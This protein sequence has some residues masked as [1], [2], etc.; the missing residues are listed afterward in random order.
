MSKI[1]TVPT[2]LYVLFNNIRMYAQ[3]AAPR[4]DSYVPTGPKPVF[5]RSNDVRNIDEKP[6]AGEELYLSVANTVQKDNIVGIQQIRNLWRIY[7]NSH[8]DRV[9]VITDG[10][11]IRGTVAPVHDVNPFTRAKEENVTKLTIKDIPLSLSDEVIRAELEAQK[12][13]VKGKIVRQKLRVNGQLINCLNGDRVVYIR[14]PSQPLPRKVVFASSFM[15]RI[16]HLGQPQTVLT[17]SRCLQTGHHVSTCNADVRCRRCKESGHLQSS[18]PTTMRDLRNPDVATAANEIHADRHD[19]TPLDDKQTNSRSSK[20]DGIEG[21][22]S[23]RQTTLADFIVH[24]PQDVANENVSDVADSGHG[25]RRETVVTRSAKR[26]GATSST[27]AAS[28][29]DERA[30]SQDEGESDAAAHGSDSDSRESS[31]GG[32]DEQPLRVEP[33]R[34]PV[35]TP[36]KTSRKS[37]NT[38]NKKSTKKK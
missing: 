34:K 5:L 4:P 37:A 14:P 8:D 16:F 12:Y 10:L 1:I 26:L 9:R 22:K 15:A 17:C 35:K 33:T 23:P 7:L 21:S 3:K 32:E 31:S 27:G 20:S 24:A 25:G 36:V 6:L 13:E 38:K 2:F 11:V 29:T 30:S 19:D 28:A 18:C